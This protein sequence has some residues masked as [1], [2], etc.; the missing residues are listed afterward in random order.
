MI[1]AVIQNQPLLAQ[2]YAVDDCDENGLS[3]V[4]KWSLN[5]LID[6]SPL[7]SHCWLLWPNILSLGWGRVLWKQY[8]SDT[9]WSPKV[10]S[11]CYNPHYVFSILCNVLLNATWYALLCCQIMIICRVIILF[12]IANICFGAYLIFQDWVWAGPSQTFLGR[13]LS[14]TVM[15]MTAMVHSGTISNQGGESSRAPIH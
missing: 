7:N 14:M 6:S 2:S 9:G 11:V 3:K 8:A 10:L 13:E 1:R 5:C 15:I 4:G 12:N